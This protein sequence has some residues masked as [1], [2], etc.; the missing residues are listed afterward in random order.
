MSQ[1]SHV[2]QQRSSYDLVIVG[3]GPAGLAT[4]IYG[5][6]HGLS[7]A[8]F[9]RHGLPLDK[10]CG[11]ALLPRGVDHLERMGVSLA[12]LRAPPFLGVRYIS[13]SVAAEGRFRGRTGLGIRRTEL[14]GAL[15]GR[16]RELGAELH[17]GQAVDSWQPTDGTVEGVAAGQRFVA[18]FLVGADGL[19]SAVRRRMGLERRTTA[20]RRFGIRRHFRVKPWSR[21][22]EVHLSDGAEAYITPVAHDEVAV[23]V[24]G[25]GDG[26][27]F[28]QLLGELPDVEAR[29]QGAEPVSEARGSGPFR[30][31]VTRRYSGRVA[32]VG[33]AAGYVDAITAEGLAIGFASAAALAR[34]VAAR[35]PLSEYEGEYRILSRGH[36]P[37]A[38]AL[39]FITARPWLRRRTMRMLADNPDALTGLLAVNDGDSWVRT[40]G[41]RGMLRM[42]AGMLRPV[43]GQARSGEAHEAV[44]A[45]MPVP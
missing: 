27:S 12:G 35:R 42:L 15:V 9:D 4:A 23:A 29:L 5:R 31:R 21:L 7:C 30:K 36:E 1:P 22:A 25:P 44:G 45:N 11:E 16:A 32:L 43:S 8:V 37:V 40:F 6:L 33:D 38:R 39:L 26:R 2:G 28:E 13:G 17:Y 3:G 14:V 18:R 41:P 24:L 20:P 19:H 10:A 34:T